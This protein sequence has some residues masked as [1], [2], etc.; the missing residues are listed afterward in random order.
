[1][2]PHEFYKNRDLADIKY[3][4]E[5]G[6]ECIEQWKDIVDYEGVYQI[7]NLGRFKSLREHKTTK[8]PRKKKMTDRIAKVSF[9]KNG[10]LR[11]G[12]YRN[13]TAKTVKVHRLVAIHFIPNPENKPEVNHKKGIKTD[14]RFFML[15]WNTVPENNQHAIDTGLIKV[16]GEDNK[17]SKLTEEQ[18][19]K[20]R[21]LYPEYNFSEIA[22]MYNVH[23][24]TI[25][26]IIKRTKW[27]HI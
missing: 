1:M 4:N 3:L 17:S 22:R 18:V 20:I 12:L 16:K 10:Y 9:D 14:N 27:N 5:E 19:V 2:N 24:S 15:E 26:R 23:H 6:I 11:T 13:K 25:S 8:W 7:S 21:T